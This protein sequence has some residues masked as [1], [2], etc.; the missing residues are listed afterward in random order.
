MHVLERIQTWSKIGN[1]LIQFFVILFFVLSFFSASQ[2]KRFFPIQ[3]DL[4]DGTT[5]L[6]FA[7]S[8]SNKVF[9]S[10]CLRKMYLCQIRTKPLDFFSPEIHQPICIVPASPTFRSIYRIIIQQ[11]LP[12]FQKETNKGCHHLTLSYFKSPQKWHLN[13]QCIRCLS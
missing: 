6:N 4:P 13:F 7:Y 11:Q 9:S 10:Q 8:K 2:F 5:K 12:N 1:I 3:N